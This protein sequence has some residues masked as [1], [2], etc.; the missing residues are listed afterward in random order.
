MRMGVPQRHGALRSALCAVVAIAMT[1][2][3][4]RAQMQWDGNIMWSNWPDGSPNNTHVGQYVGVGTNVTSC[5]N[6]GYPARADSLGTTR[7]LHNHY[8]DPL[9]PD[10]VYEANMV[11]NWIPAAGSPAWSREVV[12]IDDDYFKTVPYHGAIGPNPGDDWTTVSTWG[13]NPTPAQLAVPNTGWTIYDS[14]GAHRMDLHLA[15]MPNPRPLAVYRGTNLYSSQTWGPDSNYL[16]GAQVRVKSQANLTIAAGTVIFGERA[17]LGTLIIERGGHLTAIGDKDNPIIMT[18]DDA[19]GSMLSGCWGGV[20]LNGYARTGRANSCAGDSVASE[21]G[22]IGYYGGDDDTWDAGQLKY[23]RIEYSGKE[24]TPNN[25][26]NSFTLNGCGSNSHMDYCEAFYG[27]DDAFEW[28][29]GKMDCSHLIGE[30]G[31]DD[32]IDT[33]LGTLLRCQF[34]I[35]RNSPYY[36]I[37]GTQN[38]D[39][40]TEQDNDEL[41]F[42]AQ[43][44]N[45]APCDANGMVPEQNYYYNRTKLANCTF[46]GDHRFGANYPGPT[47]GANWRRGDSG[48]QWNSII[49]YQKVGALHV[50]DNSTWDHHCSCLPGEAVVVSAPIATGKFF[51][52]ARSA[53]NP[54][55]NHVS[56]SFD[57]PQPSQV[58]VEIYGTDGRLMKTLAEGQMSAGPH[59]IPWTTERAMPSG[60]YFYRVFAGDHVATGRIARIN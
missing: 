4:A 43:V 47:M 29:G 59:V 8:E 26:L 14:T 53:P 12:K 39:K 37:A 16:V 7:N 44:C 60:M 58:K 35:V 55:H 11:P 38:G 54:F 3:M 31:K 52:A 42:E 41:N 17:T 19:P 34:V 57:L 2:G 48:T 20:V 6:I 23:V 30:Q 10:A 28:F 49:A 1:A 56:I 33:Q 50:D 22:A 40:G 51:F 24:I 9:L 18:G 32:G 15:G 27:Q 13:N 21:G 25:E 45:R 5:I 36:T 46:I